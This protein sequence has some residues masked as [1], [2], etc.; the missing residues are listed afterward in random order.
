M[1]VAAVCWVLCAAPAFALELEVQSPRVVFAEEPF[2]VVV[3]LVN[4]QEDVS[5]IQLEVSEGFEA[6]RWR[7]QGF[8]SE[9]VN[10]RRHRLRPRRGT[11]SP[12]HAAA[13]SPSQSIQ[14]SRNGADSTACSAMR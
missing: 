13:S 9:S 10:G 8:R 6:S 1:R 7:N 11:R 14:R 4:R 2:Q 5:D 3:D 12:A